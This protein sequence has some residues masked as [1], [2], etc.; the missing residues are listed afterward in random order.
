[1]INEEI[2]ITDYLGAI[3]HEVDFLFNVESVD[4]DR[5]NW[6]NKWN[7]RTKEIMNLDFITALKWRKKRNL[8]NNILV[9]GE[10]GSGKTNVVLK[11]EKIMKKLYNLENVYFE[12]GKH[13]DF[14]L[15]HV[16]EKYKANSLIT[17]EE[18]H[19]AFDLYSYRSTGTR[20][21][22]Q[23]ID[24]IRK[25]NVHFLLITPSASNLATKLLY[26][27]INWII[28][29]SYNDWKN[30]RIETVVEYN[31]REL[32][33]ENPEFVQHS[34]FYVNWVSVSEF[35]NWDD[36][37]VKYAESIDHELAINEKR[38]RR[39]EQRDFTMKKSI[40][41]EFMNEVNTTDMT[42]N[43]RKKQVE[44]AVKGI[45]LGLT[46]SKIKGILRISDAKVN[47]AEAKYMMK[48]GESKNE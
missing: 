9:V 37:V 15:H 44:L 26:D 16:L 4:S 45:E 6:N 18:A 28:T 12:M 42:T 13:L 7:R 17:V 22:G 43:K 27:N 32:K 21:L 20:S 30:K 11:L 8:V 25:H 35:K 24:S 3:L 10:T 38:K 40:I 33:N 2:Y 14:E 36:K 5:R 1:M 19:H 39:E 41:L 48:Q 47:E 23:T 46:K 31:A 29:A 34:Q